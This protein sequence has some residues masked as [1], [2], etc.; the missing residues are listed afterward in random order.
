MLTDQF[1][2]RQAGLPFPEQRDYNPKSLINELVRGDITVEHAV[3]HAYSLFQCR[4]TQ[5]GK[6]GIRYG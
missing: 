5:L 4:A 3:H 6:L 1:K 2:K